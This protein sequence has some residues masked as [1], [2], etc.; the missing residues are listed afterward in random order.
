MLAKDGLVAKYIYAWSGLSPTFQKLAKAR[1]LEAWNLPLGVGPPHTVQQMPD[2]WATPNTAC[3][4]M[5][6]PCGN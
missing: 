3:M 1:K 4:P 2:P 5:A 6:S